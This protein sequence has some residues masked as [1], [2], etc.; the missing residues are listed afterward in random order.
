MVQMHHST[1]E[2]LLL[3]YGRSLARSWL[4]RPAAHSEAAALYGP[5]P[6]SL[7]GRALKDAEQVSAMLKSSNITGIGG[8]QGWVM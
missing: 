5:D 4:Q 3:A 2:F 7:A 1:V 8:S 6:H